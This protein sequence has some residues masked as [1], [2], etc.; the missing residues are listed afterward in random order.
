MAE[1]LKPA[2][3]YTVG[4]IALAALLAGPLGGGYLTARTH[5]AFGAVTAAR[6]TVLTS[7]LAFA[8]IVAGSIAWPGSAAIGIAYLVL[9]AVY[10][11]R[12]RRLFSV[13]IRS[14]TDY[15]WTPFPWLRAV[16][17]TA[18][19]VAAEAAVAYLLARLTR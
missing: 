19:I 18:A 4:Q 5:A 16:L 12:A 13:A 14:F 7:V 8:G 3:F 2:R 11:L 6:R 17:V 15:G 1:S 10:A 9:A